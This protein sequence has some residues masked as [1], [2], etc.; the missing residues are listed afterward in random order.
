MKLSSLGY[1]LCAVNTAVALAANS[2]HESF[3][4]GSLVYTILKDLSIG[5][6]FCSSLLHS[7]GESTQ[8]TT[9]TVVVKSCC[10]T[11]TRTKLVHAV[12]EL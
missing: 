2:R 4:D 7:L 9:S 5:R 11:Q 1:L 12:T 3:C 6:S 8:T 10:V